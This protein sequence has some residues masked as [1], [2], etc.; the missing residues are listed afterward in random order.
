M[1][2]RMPGILGRLLDTRSDTVILLR[3]NRKIKA[4]ALLL[5]AILLVAFIGPYTARYGPL[6][7]TGDIGAPPSIEHPLGTNTFGYDVYSQTVYGLRSSIVIGLLGG[8]LATLIGVVIGFLSGYFG[9]VVDEVL[10]MLTNIFLVIP[11][12]ALLI[13]IAAYI[14]QRGIA[15]ES[16]IIGAT[17]WPW[18]A[19]AIRANTLSLRN[20][21]FVHT[22]KVS[23]EGTI[24]IVVREIAPNMLS[25]IIMVFIL[26]FG[27]AILYAVGLDFIG[28]GPTKGISLGVVLQQAVLW[29]AIQLGMWWWAIPPG[30]LIALLLT[31]L[32]VI[33]TGLDEVLNP[34]L[35]RVG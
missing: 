28:L 21:E 2:A 9:G 19:R 1:G 17:S 10:M 13:I 29:N 31:S 35:R 26:Q 34:R 4:G 5:G 25:Y 33:N 12:L 20:R 22:A 27:G 24:T 6:E 30:L 3:R 18:T 14:E 23:G 15:I 7:Y 8:M 11:T 32:Y 16:I